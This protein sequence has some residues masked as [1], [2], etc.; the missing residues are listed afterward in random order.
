MSKMAEVHQEVADRMRN[1]YD[2]IRDCYST[3]LGNWGGSGTELHLNPN[4]TSELKDNLD[5]V[6]EVFRNDILPWLG[7]KTDDKGRL[8]D[9]E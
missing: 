3:V 4:Q 5:Y 7:I 2:M 6:W 8:I 9:E 1:S